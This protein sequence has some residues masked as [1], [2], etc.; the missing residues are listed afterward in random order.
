MN[1][2]P[3]NEEIRQI[4]P[5]TLVLQQKEIAGYD[6]ALTKGWHSRAFANHLTATCSLFDNNTNLFKRT[7][8]LGLGMVIWLTARKY[9]LEWILCF[10]TILKAKRLKSQ[11][12]PLVDIT[13]R[14]TQPTRWKES[15]WLTNLQ[16]RVKITQG[17]RRRDLK[18]PLQTVM[19][20]S[21]SKVMLYI[22]IHDHHLIVHHTE[23]LF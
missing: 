3:S 11:N 7:S 20:G 12:K 14:T 23:A 13:K 16:K 5:Q 19:R 10:K 15:N 18:S 6:C 2:S 1:L 22:L 21:G 8:K 9:L 4:M 17:L